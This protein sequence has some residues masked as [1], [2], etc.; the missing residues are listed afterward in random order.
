M[1][2][3]NRIQTHGTQ[4]LG[5][6]TTGYIAD[7]KRINKATVWKSL[8]RVDNHGPCSVPFVKRDVRCSSIPENPA[9]H[10]PKLNH[11]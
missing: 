3:S 8:S 1:G 2:Q 4:T 9:T 7:E 5:L 11:I 10:A 6:S